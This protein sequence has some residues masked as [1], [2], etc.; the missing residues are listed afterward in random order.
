LAVAFFN[1]IFLWSDL[2]QARPKNI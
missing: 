2:Q 1:I